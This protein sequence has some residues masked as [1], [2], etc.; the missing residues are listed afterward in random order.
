MNRHLAAC[1]EISERPLT[2]PI[3]I[4]GG[5][6]TGTTFLFRLLATDPRFRAPL[7]A[8][9]STPWRFD[10]A[11]ES[12][13]EE[14]L[15][16]P[17]GS[18]DHLHFLNPALATVHD[19]GSR[20]PEEC[21]LAMGG[22]F[23]NWG[24]SST[25][26][27]DS[28]SA[29]LADQDLTASYARYREILQTLDAEDGRRWVLKAPAHLP[30]LPRLAAAFPGACIVHLHRDIVETIASGASLFSVFRSTYSD[31]VDPCDVARFQTDQTELWLRRAS[32]FRDS[33]AASS[34]EIV[35]VRYRDLVS[36]TASV[37]KRIYTAAGIE[38]PGD[39]EGMIADYHATRPRHGR[40]VHRYTPAQFG[41]DE[42]ELRRRW[43]F[44][45][46]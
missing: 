20:L 18:Q 41:L 5:W 39:P 33:A 22:D 8:E 44:S 24:F 25:M 29:W 45:G 13:R 31:D 14:L 9:L 46:F 38:P 6:R 30:E 11:T 16:A 42:N 21:V 34:V 40:G 23:R 15:D 2:P 10:G 17:A 28:Y 37:L 4:V 1:P 3:V 27:L 26:R 35:D 19:F 7:S 32:A 36:T 12:R 43:A